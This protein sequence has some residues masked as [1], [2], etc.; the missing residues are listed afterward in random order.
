MKCV[1]K[2]T[3]VHFTDP[4]GIKKEVQFLK[5]FDDA[6]GGYTYEIH[7]EGVKFIISKDE[8]NAY[9]KKLKAMY[10][11]AVAIV[12]FDNTDEITCRR[13]CDHY[14]V[15]R[16]GKFVC[17]CDNLPEARAEVVKLKRC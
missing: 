6:E 15:L 5:I 16:A 4:Q 14:E 8:G 13:V 12:V 9:Y 11:D 1:K 17:S 10:P 3:N 7:E 2:L